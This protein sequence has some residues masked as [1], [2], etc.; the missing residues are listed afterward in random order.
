[1]RVIIKLENIFD[2]GGSEEDLYIWLILFPN[3]ITPK[4]G[5]LSKIFDIKN[6]Q[7]HVNIGFLDL[8]LL[9]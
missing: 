1:M 3:L 5:N 2:I 9:K 8:F 4:L 6:L 7:N